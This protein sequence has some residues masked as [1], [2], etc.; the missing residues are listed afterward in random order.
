MSLVLKY[1][2]WCT[3][4]G[5]G[6]ENWMGYIATKIG[7]VGHEAC[8]GDK[9]LQIW[10]PRPPT[11][12]SIISNPVWMPLQFCLQ[13]VFRTGCFGSTRHTHLQETARRRV[14]DLQLNR[15]DSVPVQWPGCYRLGVQG[16]AARF[17]PGVRDSL[18]PAVSRRIVAYSSVGTGGAVSQGVKHRERGDQGATSVH[19]MPRW[20]SA[21]IPAC[22]H[23]VHGVS[24][25]LFYVYYYVTRMAQLKGIKTAKS[26]GIALG[27]SPVSRTAVYAFLSE[28]DLPQK[29]CNGRETQLLNAAC[30]PGI[31]RVFKRK[32]KGTL[33][34]RY[35]PE[36][37]SSLDCTPR[38]P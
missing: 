10:A 25:T 3:G 38:C 11:Q 1:W 23:V 27:H 13:Q 14:W 2:M 24:F 17:Q 16:I 30:A 20:R 33:N 4:N 28:I 35:I 22:L 31:F 5:L 32:W 8:G 19:L 36:I 34:L 12:Q 26:S 29:K 15:L 7:S 37:H 18:F 6:S 9:V 21:Y